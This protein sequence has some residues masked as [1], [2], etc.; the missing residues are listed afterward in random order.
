MI[1]TDVSPLHIFYIQ[2]YLCRIVMQ[3]PMADSVVLCIHHNRCIPAV[4]AP[5]GI[6]PV[7]KDSDGGAFPAHS[8][9]CTRMARTLLCCIAAAAR[10]A[11]SPGRVTVIVIQ[12][13]LSRV[14]PRGRRCLKLS[15]GAN[16]VTFTAAAIPVTVTV[17]LLPV[18]IEPYFRWVM[19]RGQNG[20]IAC[21]GLGCCCRLGGRFARC[22][23]GRGCGRDL[24]R[25]K[26]ALRQWAA[27]KPR[28][29]HAATPNA[30]ATAAAAAAIGASGSA[31]VR[32]G[33]STGARVSAVAGIRANDS[34][35]VHAR[36]SAG[37]RARA[38]ASVRVRARASAGA[39]GCI[40]L[41]PACRR[42]RHGFQQAVHQMLQH[43]A[44]RV[45]L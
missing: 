30:N 14:V 28:V 42:C 9:A 34:A 29:V 15:A 7:A 38:S 5:I 27:E 22:C 32:A 10:A 45:L 21:S 2:S 18:H 1:T 44:L 41:L 4:Q 17:C 19:G 20:C 3:R 31:G 11:A 23:L 13:Y 6:F 40:A 24:G 33:A 37:A 8:A 25:R 35:V 12:S 16:S 26:Q 36:T 39:A 43:G